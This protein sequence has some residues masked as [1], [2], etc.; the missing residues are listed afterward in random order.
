[1]VLL[2]GTVEVETSDGNV[3]RF[4]PGDILLLEDTWGKG[5]RLRNTGVDYLHFFI[6]QL[7]IV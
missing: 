4:K 1:M 2:S 3:Q 7:P 6:V 5:H